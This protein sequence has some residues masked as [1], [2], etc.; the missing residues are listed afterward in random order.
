MAWR[1]YILQKKQISTD[2]GK[3]WVDAEPYT[4]RISEPIAIFD[5]YAECMNM[6]YRW[7]PTDIEYCDYRTDENTKIVFGY[8]QENIYSPSESALTDTLVYH[9]GI[10]KNGTSDDVIVTSGEVSSYK[11]NAIAIKVFDGVGEIDTNAFY[12]WS[13]VKSI[14]LPSTLSVIGSG[15][16]ASMSGL[17]SIIINASTPPLLYDDGQG[18]YTQFDGSDSPIYVPVGSINAYKTA[19]GWNTY[20]SR[21]FAIT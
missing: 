19:N 8:K 21:L 9:E 12:Q 18:N 11:D 10:E 2:A 20:E 15:A 1:Q 6:L 7:I 5:S 16:F 13:T 3:T 14:E 17:T 4:T